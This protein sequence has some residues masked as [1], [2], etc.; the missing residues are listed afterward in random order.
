MVR[1]QCPTSLRKF[2]FCGILALIYA[3][4]L[5]MP[6]SVSKLKMLLEDVKKIL[7]MKKGKWNK[8]SPK[9][10]GAISI[11]DTLCLLHHYKSCDFEVLRTKADEKALT[12]RKWV[13]CVEAN[14]C[15][16][17]HLKT[18]AFFVEV[19]AVKSKWRIYDQGGVHTR[20][21]FHL[22]EKV[23]GYGGQQIRAIVQVTY[24]NQKEPSTRPA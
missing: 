16:I 13:K 1:A 21:D 18:H 9:H 5:P 10:T 11:T 17:V 12:L 14:T 19:L 6:T 15:Y 2:G 20:K 3:A 23:G 22:M 8:A 7:Y 4:R 24:T